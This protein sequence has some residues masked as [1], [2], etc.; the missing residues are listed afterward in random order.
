MAGTE[1]YTGPKM[2]SYYTVNWAVP[3]SHVNVNI[4]FATAASLSE[5]AHTGMCTE[6]YGER[7]CCLKYTDQEL[8]PTSPLMCQ[9]RTYGP[10]HACKQ[11]HSSQ[12]A[13]ADTSLLWC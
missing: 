11:Y 5:E 8:E 6:A 3:L 4:V 13:S 9:R 1:M 2:L 7:L 10:L 12:A